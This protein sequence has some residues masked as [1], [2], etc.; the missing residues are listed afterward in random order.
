MDVPPCYCTL[1]NTL[2]SNR[3]TGE[4]NKSL[5][6]TLSPFLSFPFSLPPCS[7]FFSLL[8]LSFLPSPCSFFF[9]GPP[10]SFFLLPYPSFSL[11]LPPCSFF[12]SLL[13]L[14]FLPS[15]CSFFFSGPPISFFL[16]PYPSFSLS[17]PPCSLSSSPYLSFSTFSP[18]LCS[19]ELEM[20]EI[21]IRSEALTEKS[22]DQM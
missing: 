2:N 18:S 4:A 12:F 10:I 7:F 9:S 17:L 8:F 21:C 11:S 19:A 16:L 22:C 3:A 13:F 15:P 5:Y 14:S 1:T 6:C 20:V